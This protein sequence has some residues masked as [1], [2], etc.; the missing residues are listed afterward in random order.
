M[1]RALCNKRIVFLLGN[2][3]FFEKADFLL[4]RLAIV[5]VLDLGL[6]ARVQRGGA[7]RGMLVELPQLALAVQHAGS[8]TPYQHHH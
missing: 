6:V 4:V 5:E 3:I 8:A 1:N 7:A 2:V